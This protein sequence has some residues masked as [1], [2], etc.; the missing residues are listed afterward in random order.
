MC[1]KFI[2]LKLLTQISQLCGLCTQSRFKWKKVFFF[3][4][5][6]KYYTFHS[7]DV[8]IM[9]SIVRSALSQHSHQQCIQSLTSFSSLFR[10]QNFCASNSWFSCESNRSWHSFQARL[11]M[12]LSLFD[13]SM[14]FQRTIRSCLSH[15]LEFKSFFVFCTN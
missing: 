1:V 8:R 7:L 13:G 11:K 3:F 4:L 15:G 5:V 12:E 2:I 6:C 14:L 10:Y 9:E